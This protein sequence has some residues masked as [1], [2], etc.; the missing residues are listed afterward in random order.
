MFADCTKTDC[1]VKTGPS[2]I[3][4]PFGLLS[5][6]AIDTYLQA[7]R[8]EHEIPNPVLDCSPFSP[9][10]ELRENSHQINE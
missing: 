4:C 8:L 6:A 2:P 3:V 1:V 7:A 10:L 5:I 9:T